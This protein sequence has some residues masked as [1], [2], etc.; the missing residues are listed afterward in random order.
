MLRAIT[1]APLDPAAPT[2]ADVLPRLQALRRHAAYPHVVCAD[3][4]WYPA[5]RTLS[6]A[7][8]QEWLDGGTALA[9]AVMALPGHVAIDLTAVALEHGA[10]ALAARI[11]V[12]GGTARSARATLQIT[13]AQARC[14]IDEPRWRRLA[15]HVVLRR[16]DLAGVREWMAAWPPTWSPVFGQPLRS[17]AAVL[18]TESFA[19]V[20]PLNRL[21]LPANA[22][23]LPVSI[24]LLP[25]WSRVGFDTVRLD[26][27]LR[28]VIAAADWLLDETSL[29]VGE[30]Y[31]GR[32]SPSSACPGTTRS[33]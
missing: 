3:G 22:A 6:G 20:S 19:I 11:D 14:V 17:T 12:L 7:A 31:L 25:Y 18:G 21:C 33:R 24:N 1:N 10:A 5:E 8:A 13:A 4:H 27:A 9:A 15:C 2:S 23:V 32:V 16:A 30:R 29:A 26:A 28:D